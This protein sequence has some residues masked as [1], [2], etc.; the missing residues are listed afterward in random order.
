MKNWLDL[1]IPLRCSLDKK[2]RGMTRA[3][4]GTRSDNERMLSL[5]RKAGFSID[6]TR[7]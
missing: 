1:V 5:A 6:H 3:I 7:L 4:I 2:E